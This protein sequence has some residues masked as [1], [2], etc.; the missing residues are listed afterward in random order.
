MKHRLLLYYKP[1]CPY[2]QKV[3]KYLDESGI[4][5]AKK[6]IKDDPS[7]KE[8]LIEKTG[9]KQVPCLMIDG[10]PLFESDDIIKWLIL[11]NPR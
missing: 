8:E 5:I 7:A 2:C 3:L 1:S 9:K 4:N 11:E 10:K 6:N